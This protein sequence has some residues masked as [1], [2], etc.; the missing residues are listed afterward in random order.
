MASTLASE[1]PSE[2]AFELMNEPVDQLRGRRQQLGPTQ[3][4]QLFAAARAA[5]TRLTL[6]LSGGCWG[7]AEGLVALDP[8]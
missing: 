5:A 2:V 7:T 8:R 6:I 4:K 1:D 3:L